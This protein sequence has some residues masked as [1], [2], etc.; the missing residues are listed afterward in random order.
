MNKY[1][2]NG[3]SVSANSYRF[4]QEVLIDGEYKYLF[5][6]D[7]VVDVGANIGTFSLW[8]YP[9]AKRIY[10]IEP[11]P[12]PISLLNRTIEDNK[13]TKISTHQLALTSSN[14]DRYLANT[15]DLDY[16]SG[17]INETTGI[18]VKSVQ[19]DT[20]MVENNIEYIDLLKIDIEKCELEVF[21]SKGFLNS[22][23]KVGTIIG[24]Y[25]NGEIQEKIK[26]L[27]NGMGFRYIDLTGAN[28]SGKF[29]ARRL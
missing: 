14:G 11:N 2:V 4:I 9:Y 28:S 5:N 29:I 27:L 21:E 24:E 1:P 15:E 16:G 7:V 10:A 13:L 20:F 26:H 22:S 8:I 19:L 6:Y 12:S 17:L 18:I 3:I 23:S 25:H